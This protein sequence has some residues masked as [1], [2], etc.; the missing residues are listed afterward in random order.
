M[1]DYFD[2]AADARRRGLSLGEW[3]LELQKEDRARREAE[4]VQA[5]ADERCRRNERPCHDM[6]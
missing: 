6:E 2:R 3:Q 5:L 1:P 4:R